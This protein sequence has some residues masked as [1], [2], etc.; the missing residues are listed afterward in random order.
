[1][2][3]ATLE[4]FYQMPKIVRQRLRITE[5]CDLNHSPNDRFNRVLSFNGSQPWAEQIGTN[6]GTMLFGSRVIG[7]CGQICIEEPVSRGHVLSR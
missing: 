5:Y 2:T 1:M 7:F 4:S 3:D 6:G